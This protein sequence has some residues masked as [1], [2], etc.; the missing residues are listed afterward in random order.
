VPE[1]STDTIDMPPYIIRDPS[2]LTANEFFSTLTK[3]EVLYMSDVIFK[4]YPLRNLFDVLTDE[5]KEE[6]FEKVWKPLVQQKITGSLTLYFDPDLQGAKAY[7]GELRQA[8]I[9]LLEERIDAF[10][11]GQGK[12]FEEEEEEDEGEAEG[13]EGEAEVA[14]GAEGAEGEA[15]GEGGEGEGAEGEGAEGED[16]EG[17]EG[18]EEAEEEG[19]EEEEAPAPPPP[20]PLKAKP[21]ARAKSKQDICTSLSKDTT[22][23]PFIQYIRA[24]YKVIEGATNGM[25]TELDPYIANLEKIESPNTVPAMEIKSKL[26]PLI[27]ELQRVKG[28]MLQ[29]KG[30][31]RRSQGQ[32]K[33]TLLPLTQ[34]LKD[35]ICRYYAQIKALNPGPPP[36]GGKR[37]TRKKRS[38]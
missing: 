19:A 25:P 3:S 21:V 33:H 23:D 38:T 12:E 22:N 27:T 11:I 29:N 26:Q 1:A 31:R 32:T 4:G 6:F 36:K 7:I 30:T 37:V 8:Q 16:E 9:N 13:A 20:A 24:I 28:V 35:T 17:A 15:E 2:T 10:L 34:S 14:E 5:R 18:A